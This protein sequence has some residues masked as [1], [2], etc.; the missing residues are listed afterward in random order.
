MRIEMS[1]NGLQQ[2]MH[3][4][5]NSCMKILYLRPKSHGV[6]FAVRSRDT[7]KLVINVAMTQF[8]H[9]VTWHGQ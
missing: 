6:I 8:V 2:L 1:D 4:Y 5:W 3:S 9:R 7:H